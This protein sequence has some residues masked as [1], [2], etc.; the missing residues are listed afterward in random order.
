MVGWRCTIRTVAMKDT[1]ISLKIERT[2]K[3]KLTVVAKAENR[4][5]SNLIE[6]LIKE[7]IG[8]FEAKNGR[9]RIS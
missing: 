4:T 7:E 2:L 1:T 9:I 8:R 3:A 6:K 5:I